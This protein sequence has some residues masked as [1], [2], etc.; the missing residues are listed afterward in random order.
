MACWGF[1][2]EN[3]G[4]QQVERLRSEGRNGLFDV[5]LRD[6]DGRLSLDLSEEASDVL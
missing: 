6:E 5:A 1:P 4:L 2:D 3:I